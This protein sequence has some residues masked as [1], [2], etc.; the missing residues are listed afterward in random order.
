MGHDSMRAAL[1]YQHTNRGADKRIADALGARLTGKNRTLDMSAGARGGLA[2]TSAKAAERKRDAS[3]P[4]FR[5][6]HPGAGDGIRRAQR[7]SSRF[8]AKRFNAERPRLK[9]GGTVQ[10]WSG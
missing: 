5:G 6:L 4:V 3:A 2:H 10:R 7:R 8:P 1:I 9:S